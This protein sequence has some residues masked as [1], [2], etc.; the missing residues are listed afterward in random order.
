MADVA[1]W[2]IAFTATSDDVTK[3]NAETDRDAK[4]VVAFAHQHGFSDIEIETVPTKVSDT[5]QFGGNQ[6][7]SN[8]RYLVKGGIQIRS[9]NVDRVAQTGQ[10]TGDLIRQGIV[11]NL[12][13][14]TASPI[15]LPLH[16]P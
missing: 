6:N 1:V 4:L 12:E 10:L 7:R 9:A 16:Q 3:A 8:G 11:L 14:D 5:E 13:P 15:P 2:N